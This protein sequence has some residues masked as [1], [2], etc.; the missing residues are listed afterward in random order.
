MAYEL[1]ETSWVVEPGYVCVPG[2]PVH[3]A[4][5]VSSGIAVTVYD[6][7]RKRGGMAHYVRPYREGHR[8][9]PL[10]AA[11][12][13]VTLVKILSSSGS[14][15]RHW[16]VYLYGGAQNPD[17]SRHVEGLGDKNVAVGLEILEKL[18]V[19]VAGTDV[20]GRRGRK[21]IFHTGSGETAIARV[22]RL[23]SSDWYPEVV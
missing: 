10:F 18:G 20:G 19:P 4:A 16:E 15:K 9:T 14:R 11:P 23:R 5:V 7:K 12:S 21:I 22:D 2:E 6:R 8:S 17:C 3:L 1:V 13:I